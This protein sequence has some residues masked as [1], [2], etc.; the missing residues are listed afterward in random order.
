MSAESNAVPRAPALVQVENDRFRLL[1]IVRQYA[2]ERLATDARDRHRD[3]FLALAVPSGPDAG[4]YTYGGS[5][6][7]E[8]ELYGPSAI[9]R[10]VHIGDSGIVSLAFASRVTPKGIYVTQD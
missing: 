9:S 3:L 2:L 4:L 1:E 6:L 8:D 5:S 10:D 7:T